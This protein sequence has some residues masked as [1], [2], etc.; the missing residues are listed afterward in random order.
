M[1]KE[2]P[3]YNSLMQTIEFGL[4]ELKKTEEMTQSEY[5]KHCLK[6]KYIEKGFVGINSVLRK[7]ELCLNTTK[8][9]QSIV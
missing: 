3:F 4:E 7:E 6:L 5:K 2:I 9:Y 8:K 1:S